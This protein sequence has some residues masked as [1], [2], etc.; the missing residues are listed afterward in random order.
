MHIAPGFH[1][2]VIFY[3]PGLGTSTMPFTLKAGLDKAIAAAIVLSLMISR[4]QFQ[5]VGIFIQKDLPVMLTGIAGI[6]LTGY[7]LGIDLDIKFGQLTLAFA[8]FH[9]FV[10]CMAEEAF[11]RLLVQETLWQKLQKSPLRFLGPLAGQVNQYAGFI[12]FTLSASLFTLAHFHTGPG[13]ME[14]MFLIFLAALLYAG[15]YWRTRSYITSVTAHFL[16]NFLHLSL[17]TYPATF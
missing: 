7:I 16:L 8:F 12:A 5:G 14:R 9:F 2:E 15:I 10:T 13:A 3:S 11:F 4:L 1:N 17:F 6:L